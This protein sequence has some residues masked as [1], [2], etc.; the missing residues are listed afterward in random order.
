M[1]ISAGDIQRT[2]AYFFCQRLAGPNLDV[3]THPQSFPKEIEGVAIFAN[4]VGVMA[5]R[6][7]IA[8]WCELARAAPGHSVDCFYWE[9]EGAARIPRAAFRLIYCPEAGAHTRAME[10]SF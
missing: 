1:A 6:L 4:M 7:E 8:H 10:K 5:A 2:S 3:P 9:G